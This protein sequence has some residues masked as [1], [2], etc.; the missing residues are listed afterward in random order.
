MLTTQKIE[1]IGKK[2]FMTTALNKE[3]ETFVVHIIALS[4]VDSG[5]YPSW[6]AQISLLDVNEVTISFEYADYTDLF[7]LD[8]AA[9]LPEYTGMNNHFID[10]IDDKQLFYS[11]IYSLGLVEIETLKTYIEINLANGFIRPSNSPA[12]ASIL[13]IC[14]KDGRFWLYIDYQGL[15]N[16]TIRNWYPLPLIGESFDRLSRAKRFTQFDLTNAYHQIQI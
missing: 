8:S 14:K 3:D 12:D 9:K 4:I 2:E 13:F 5:V 16:L 6:Q 10:L 1:I 15:N 7:L 11:P